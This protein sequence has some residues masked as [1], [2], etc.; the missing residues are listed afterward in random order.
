[1]PLWACGVYF[2]I[3]R[4]LYYFLV[5]QK[6]QQRK[7]VYVLMCLLMGT[8]G[9]SYGSHHFHKGTIIHTIPISQGVAL[10]IMPEWNWFDH[11]VDSSNHNIEEHMSQNADSQ[12][13]MLLMD[14]PKEKMSNSVIYQLENV[15]HTYGVVS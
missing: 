11:D 15:I 12:V 9:L 4:L 13:P 5:E 10:L 7:V 2:G 1:M 3:L 6:S 8:V 14:I